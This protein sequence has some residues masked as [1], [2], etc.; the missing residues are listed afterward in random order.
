MWFIKRTSQMKTKYVARLTQEERAEL[1]D[2]VS[3]GKAAAQKIKH[4]NVLLKIDAD[5]SRWNDRQAAEAFA[6]SARTVFS[7]RQRL[8]E[9]GLEAALTRKKRERPPIEPL[10]DG[11]KEARLLQIACSRPPEGRA[12]WTLKLLAEEMIT[13]EVVESISPQTVMRTLK[14]TL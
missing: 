4:A 13:L 8:V 6:C 1:I 11:E 10:L 2:L 5:G 12:R 3:K 14:K 7:I 9:E